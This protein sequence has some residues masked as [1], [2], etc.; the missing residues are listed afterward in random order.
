VPA[1]IK[2]APPIALVA[3]SLSNQVTP[4][5]AEPGQAISP[6]DIGTPVNVG[7]HPDAI[8]I[9]PN[10]QWAYVANFGSDN[11]TPIN[12]ATN[13]A[14]A[15]G[16]WITVGSE[17]DAIA[18]TPNGKWA[19]VANSGDGT[20]SKISL[21]T[22]EV[23]DTI[24][25]GGS[26]SGIAISPDGST[27]YVTDNAPG[28]N[29]LIPLDTATDVVAPG[30]AAG[31][32]PLGVSITPD[33]NL[34]LVVD[35]GSPI[36]PGEV[37][38]VA[39]PAGTP[40]TPVDVGSNPDAVAISPDG[41]EAYVSNGGDGT[42]SEIAIS[43][44]TL[45]TVTAATAGTDPAGLA[46]TPDGTGAYV[47][48]DV[49]AAPT[50]AGTVAVLDVPAPG[51]VPT[52]VSVG[53]GA[54]AVA[55]TPD[56]APVAA[57]AV[58][59]APAGDA[60]FFSAAQT[61]FPSAPGASYTWNFGDG[62]SSTTTTTP[63]TTH[64][65]ATGGTYDASVTVTDT[66]GTSTIQ[67]FTGQTVSLNGGSGAEA[68]ASVPVPYVVPT[69]TSVS[70][71]SGTQGEATSLI[72][73]G[74]NFFGV[75]SV[76]IGTTVITGYT[77][78]SAGTEISNLLAPSTL[79]AGSYD[80]TVTNPG[81][82]SPITP[83]DVFTDVPTAT[84][85]PD[86]PV[87][88]AMSTGFGPQSGGTGVTI[89]GTDLSGATAVDFGATAAAG[90]TVNS[91]GTQITVTSPPASA[92]GTV[93]VTVVTPDGTS[94]ITPADAFTYLAPPPPSSL[95][96]ITSV[97]PDHGPTSGLTDVTVTGTDLNGLTAVD[98]GSISAESFISDGPDS[99]TAIS[100]AVANPGT[101]DVTVTTIEGTSLVV[102]AD[103]F[104]Y[105][106]SGSSTGPTVTSVVPSV[107]PID[108]GNTVTINGTGFFSLGS[109]AVDFGS[110]AAPHF[111][112]NSAGTKIT[113][114]A[115]SVGSSQSVD[116]TVTNPLG[117]S[118][119]T[120]ADVYTY[121]PDADFAPTIT[122]VAPGSG[123]QSGGTSVTLTGTNLG[124]VTDIFFGTTDV[125]SF[126]VDGSGDQLYVDSP[127]AATAGTVTVTVTNPY[128]T[129]A[130]TTATSF[131]FLPLNPP[132]T[133]P[134]VT[135]VLPG[136][137]PTAGGTGV[138]ITGT[139]FSDATAVDFGGE[140]ATS[141]TVN[142]AGTQISA[143]SPSVGSPI[144]VDVTVTASAMTSP[145]TTDDVFTYVA[146]LAPPAP[147]VTLV[148]PA[149]GPLTGGT[150]VTITGTG[151]TGT[152]W[153][154]FGS[155]AGTNVVVNPAGTQLTVT[156]PAGTTAGTVPVSLATIDGISV[157]S[158]SSAF[159]YLLLPGS[160]TAISPHRL[161]DTRVSGSGGP[162]AA[163]ETRQLQ[164][165]GVDGV[166]SGAIGVMVNLTVTDLTSSTSVS[167]WPA[168]GT[169]P[170]TP[171]LVAAKGQIVSHLVE[172]PLNSSG[173]IS[174]WNRAGS[175]QVVV[176]L[177][178]Y[179]TESAPGGDG[180]ILTH[181]TL[182]LN[183]AAKGGGG[184]VTKGHPRKL[185]LIGKAGVPTFDVSAVMIELTSSS[186]TAADWATVYPAGTAKPVAS[187]LNWVKGQS[188]TNLLT[189]TL[190]SGGA[191]EL[192]TQNGSANFTVVGGQGAVPVGATSV[193]LDVT[194]SGASKAATLTAWPAGTFKP[195][196]GGLVVG[197]GGTY[198]TEMLVWIGAGGDV[199]LSLSAGHA[200]VTVAVQ[201]YNQ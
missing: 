101:V 190:G 191:I 174:I 59:P 134:Q 38:P 177:E 14:V 173:Q 147:T 24:T 31:T 49:P 56:Q 20:V 148:S 110:E 122:L 97:T 130:V 48:D 153:V 27:A 40:G 16:A 78:N 175:T 100:P 52:D 15:A 81:G 29:D 92:A 199:D 176:D 26:P 180:F 51:A 124:S 36:V 99:L 90:F 8:A 137:G 159:T 95:P 163:G 103:A 65:Y 114:Q 171:N 109:T 30:I 86:A 135:S 142:A 183:T 192:A 168:G 201:G 189:A 198:S 10:G 57:L 111:S 37:T 157:P 155:A 91:A 126:S 33:G 185:V 71:S 98:F 63:T 61:T 25:V 197:T 182:V 133:G 47:A 184:P 154:D 149:T 53:A 68:T 80:V 160:Y 41:T 23:V 104:T 107:G 140:A 127:S 17:P 118:L 106:S 76:Q 195:A 55:I 123:P 79:A 73:T 89:T 164:V 77:V 64:T 62:S 121:Q 1:A 32:D 167:V 193:F 162:F 143:V 141:F 144:A 43:S 28:Y 34:A 117:T 74:T 120:A 200:N 39:L 166:P 131:T 146:G 96:V 18:I 3:D 119:I 50:A 102:P 69:V 115:P 169:Q 187:Q 116:V 42:L 54:D 94:A 125:T 11:I 196:I 179:V 83:F 150:S 188:T 22:G 186:T 21:A 129:S 67:S 132:T 170:S 178:G 6:N 105:D 136:V 151:L 9:T 12:I 158:T 145:V 108:G 2:N 82:T 156:A 152:L 85:P 138:T 128:G 58:T 161:L 172:L 93:D 88:T 165:S 112:V 70:P 113:A 4:I 72:V 139:G 46:I 35:R 60:S 13:T 5:L 44:D 19:F 7:V 194:V 181:P 45:G 87:V 66:D 84:P 75:S